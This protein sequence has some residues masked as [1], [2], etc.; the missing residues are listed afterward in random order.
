LK[1]IKNETDLKSLSIRRT[2][3]QLF[4]FVKQL[5]DIFSQ[6]SGPAASA[7]GIKGFGKNKLTRNCAEFWFVFVAMQIFRQYAVF[8]KKILFPYHS[9]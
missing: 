4:S 5:T 1:K 7:R 2:Y 9:V 6:A 8:P 3:L